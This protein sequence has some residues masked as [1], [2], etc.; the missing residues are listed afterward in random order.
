VNSR[1]EGFA[2]QYAT[3]S[4][5]ELLRLASEGGLVEEAELALGEELRRRQITSRSIRRERIDRKRA[6]LQRNVGSNPYFASRGTGLTFRGG[7]KI[8]DQSK[9]VVKT[10][11]LVL[12]WMSVVPLGSYRISED[13]SARGFT[14]LKKEKLQWDHVITGWMQTGSVVIL[15]LCAW[16]WLKWWIKHS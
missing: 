7:K 16:L 6:E 13:D 9:G 15:L 12:F 10:R 3:Y 14:I 11:W 4:D 1:T 8:A 2:S 5:S